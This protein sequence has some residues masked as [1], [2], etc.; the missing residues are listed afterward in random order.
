MTC[1]KKTAAVDAGIDSI[2]HGYV[3]DRPLLK[4]MVK[5]NTWLVPTIMVTHPG[6]REYFE[7]MSA[8]EKQLWG[9]TLA[10][11]AH[12]GAAGQNR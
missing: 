5:S 2:E 6:G 11:S 3:L 7:R 1:Q 10:A 9:L 4:K 12:A 8:A